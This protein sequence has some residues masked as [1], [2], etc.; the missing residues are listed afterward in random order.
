MVDVTAARE[1]EQAL[2]QAQ[3]E[4]AHVTRLT[5]LGQLTASIAHTAS[6]A[7]DPNSARPISSTA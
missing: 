7:P 2:Q 6:L 1:T 5:T 3:A 4:L